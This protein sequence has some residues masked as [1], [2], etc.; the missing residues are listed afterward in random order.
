MIAQVAQDKS[1]EVR[2]KVLKTLFEGTKD[3]KHLPL[4]FLALYVLYATDPEKE[5]LLRV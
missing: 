1:F 5:L 4:R 3:V 2:E